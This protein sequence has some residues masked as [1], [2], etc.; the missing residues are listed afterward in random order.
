MKP[1]SRLPSTDAASIGRIGR[2]AA[3]RECREVGLFLHFH[4]P[5]VRAWA[6]DGAPIRSS[7]NGVPSG[8]GVP[9]ARAA[10]AKAPDSP[11]LFGFVSSFP[12]STADCRN[13]FV[14]GPPAFRGP[15]RSAPGT[16]C[17]DV[18]SGFVFALSAYLLAGETACVLVARSSGDRRAIRMGVPEAAATV[19]KPRHQRIS[20]ISL[21]LVALFSH[22]CI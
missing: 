21:D 14:F 20:F 13:G 10:L 9:G 22:F 7:G 3:H 6:T 5:R 1:R 18:R 11:R 8:R 12:R 2:I 15:S 19:A 4:R 17:L 16:T